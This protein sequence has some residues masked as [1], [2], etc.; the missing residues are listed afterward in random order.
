MHCMCTT[1]LKIAGRSE[2]C[3]PSSHK[4]EVEAAEDV[5]EPQQ[6]SGV[7]E[8]MVD[9]IPVVAQRTQLVGLDHGRQDLRIATP[10]HDFRIQNLVDYTHQSSKQSL[11]GE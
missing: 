2:G 9:D 1:A 5:D 10:K 7:A 8:R 4:Q 11:S 3:G 6:E